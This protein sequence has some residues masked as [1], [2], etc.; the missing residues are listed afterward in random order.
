[1]QNEF[2][3]KT[4]WIV[5]ADQGIGLEVMKKFHSLGYNV[6]GIDKTSA[7]TP[8][9]LKHLVH[10]CDISNHQNM[11][12]LC[13][14]LLK[15]SPPDYFVH[16]AG[17]LHFG[18]FY[19]MKPT[20]ITECFNVN[21]FSALY[22]MQELV[23]YFK[24]KQQGSVVIISSN[25]ARTPRVGMSIYGA[26]KAAMTYL[27]K[28][29]ALELAQDNVRVNIVS[30]GSTN[31]NMLTNMKNENFDNNIIAGDLKNYKIGIPLQKIANPN[32]IAEAVLFLIQEQ[33]SHIT[34]HDLVVDGGATLGC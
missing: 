9:Y 30:P 14:Q 31:T 13:Q 1:M 33:S 28:V 17:I 16:V 7:N 34:M 2:L 27:A 21:T 15:E 11:I 12:L 29:M 24:K 32:E 4:V 5:G 23:P 18:D 25:A 6:I 3:Q 22:F 26:S 19:S 10:L 8:E 20:Q